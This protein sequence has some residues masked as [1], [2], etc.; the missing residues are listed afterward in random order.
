VTTVDANRRKG[1]FAE[2]IVAAWLSRQCLVRHVSEG[3]DIGIDLYCESL[4]G[5]SPY[6]HFWVQVKAIGEDNF[7]PGK[8]AHYRF[9]R[10]HLEYW[11]QQPVPVY[12]FLVPVVGTPPRDP[13]F[14]FGIRLSDH[15]VREGLPTTKTVTLSTEEG[16]SSSK[17]EDDLRGFIRNIVPYDTAALGLPKGIIAPID[18]P[19]PGHLESFP[20]DLTLEHIDRIIS[21]IRFAVEMSL[22][23]LVQAKD[24]TKRLK[25]SRRTVESLAR[26]LHKDLNVIGLTA[27]A[28]SRFMEADFD[29][30]KRFFDLASELIRKSVKDPDERK[31]QLDEIDRTVREVERIRQ[32]LQ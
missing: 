12:A 22:A 28:N 29:G 11:A 17:I 30:T 32:S 7:E 15:L 13:E 21:T 9:E 14:I 18:E 31:K 16:F 2:T 26:A 6:K 19:D 3:T 25:S 5:D 10:R 20:K 1:N 27:L 4:I 23:D 24:A 8:S